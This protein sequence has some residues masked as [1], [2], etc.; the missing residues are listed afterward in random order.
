MQLMT[1]AEE[2]NFTSLGLDCADPI[3]SSLRI[4]LELRP[5]KQITFFSREIFLRKEFPKT[6]LFSYNQLLNQNSKQQSLYLLTDRWP[7]ISK[8]Q[9][10]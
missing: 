6:V 1:V 9:V 8:I 3:L 7:S 5:K 10:S 2:P 4:I